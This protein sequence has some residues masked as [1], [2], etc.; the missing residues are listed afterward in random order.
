[1]LETC[2]VQIFTPAGVYLLEYGRLR[3]FRHIASIINM[4]IA[5]ARTG[6]KYQNLQ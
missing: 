6:Y 1:M 2:I 5:L 4:I 3:K